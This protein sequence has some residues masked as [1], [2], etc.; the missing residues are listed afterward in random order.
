MEKRVLEFAGLE[1]RS[2]LIMGDF[3][4][5]DHDHEGRRQ[6][7]GLVNV[8][9]SAFHEGWGAGKTDP[10]GGHDLVNRKIVSGKEKSQKKMVEER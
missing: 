10:T 4:L 5:V 3:A 7:R 1:S 2:R 9:Y 8:E 6:R